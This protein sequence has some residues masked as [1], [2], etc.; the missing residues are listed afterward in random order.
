MKI[1]QLQVIICEST[2]SAIQNALDPE[3]RKGHEGILYLFGRT[4]GVV[5]TIIS[6]FR[7]NSVTGPG[8]FKVSSSEMAKVIRTAVNHNLQ[9][10]GQIHT[11]PKRAFHSEGDE[12]GAKIRYSGFVSIVLPEY[13]RYLPD[14]SEAAIF[15]FKKERGFVEIGVDNVEIV[16]DTLN[17]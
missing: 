13:G 12:L 4:D 6:I 14:L 15:I 5:S 11:H 10:V 9:V 1:E 7:P 8:Y 16:S 2:L 3:I 17:E